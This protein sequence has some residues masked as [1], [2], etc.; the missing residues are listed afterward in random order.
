M[1]DDKKD[2]QENELA[3]IPSSIGPYDIKEKINEGGYSK[4]YLGISKYTNDKVAIKIIDK[5]LF[6]KNPED[7]LL[8]RNEIDILKLLKHR[9]ILTLYEIYESNQYFF[10]ITEHLSS[11]L[12]NLILNK[13]RLN[14]S[15]A[16]KIFVQLVDALQY[17][18]K[19]QICHR[20]IRVEHV[21]FDNNN[22]PKIID[23][24]YSCFYKKGKTL[25]EPIGSLSYAC[26][27][28]IQQK[29]YD[30]EL[31]DVWSLGVCLYVLLCGY[32]PFSEEDDEKNNKLIVSGKVDYPKEIGNVCK[33]LLKKM[34]EVNP[35]KRYNLLKISR[36]PWIKK[37][38]DVKIIGGCNIY[39]MVYPVDERI[40]KIVKEYGLDPKKVEEDLKS[41]KFNVNTGLFKVIVKKI[42]ELKLSSISDFTSNSFVDYTKDA[43]NKIQGGESKY[44]NYLTKL[45]ERN[46]K[47]QKNIFDY[48]KKEDNVINKL[49]EL[50]KDNENHNEKTKKEKA[51]TNKD[52]T[53]ILKSTK[54]LIS[55][56]NNNNSKK[57]EKEKKDQNPVIQ[58]FIE[59]YKQENSEFN[60][61]KS[62]SI[63]SYTSHG[64]NKQRKNSPKLFK[65]KINLDSLYE[66]P[67]TKKGAKLGGKNKFFPMAA[68]GR[69]SQMITLFRKPP[70]RLRRTSVSASQMQLLMRKPKKEEEEKKM[71]E[72]V[73]EQKDEE[74]NSEDSNESKS[75]KSVK[76]EKVEKE[77]KEKDKY[78]FDFGDD[79]DEEGGEKSDEELEQL[80]KQIENEDKSNN[81]IEEEKEEKKDDSWSSHNKDEEED[82]NL[83]KGTKCFIFDKEREKKIENLIIFNDDINLYITEMDNLRKYRYK[84]FS[85]SSSKIK[86]LNMKQ[87]NENDFDVIESIRTKKLAENK[88]KNENENKNNENSDVNKDEIKIKRNE[89]NKEKDLSEKDKEN[90]NENKT[91]KDTDF[92]IKEN[93]KNETELKND[94]R[95]IKSKAP[96]K[97]L[98]VDDKTL[99]DKK[100]KNIIV[101][102]NTSEDIRKEN[103]NEK[104]KIPNIIN[105]K[106][107]KE[108][109][110]YSNEEEEEEEED[111]DEKQN[112]NLTTINDL[113]SFKPN[114]TVNM[115]KGRNL[116]LDSEKEKEKENE[117]DKK[118]GLKNNNKNSLR[119]E[120]YKKN[121]NERKSNDILENEDKSE[122]NES[123]SNNKMERKRSVLDS[124]RKMKEKEKELKNKKESNEENNIYFQYYN[125]RNK[126]IDLDKKIERHLNSLANRP[127]QKTKNKK[128]QTITQY[129]ENRGKNGN[130]NIDG[131]YNK[132]INQS[133]I[134]YLIK[135]NLENSNDEEDDDKEESSMTETQNNSSK[136]KTKII[137][138][139]LMNKE[140]KKINNKKPIT[141][142]NTDKKNKIENEGNTNTQKEMDLY[143]S[144]EN[145]INI[146][147]F[148]SIKDESK[149]KD[150]ET[151]FKNNPLLNKIMNFNEEN[152]GDNNEEEEEEENK[153]EENKKK[154]N[155][156]HKNASVGK[157]AAMPKIRLNT[158]KN[159][160]ESKKYKQKKKQ[161]PNKNN[162]ITKK[163]NYKESPKKNKKPY[164][165]KSSHKSID[166]A[167]KK[168]NNNKL[169]NN[170]NDKLL[171]RQQRLEI[172]KNKLKEELKK[173]DNIIIFLNKY[174][175]NENNQNFE[176]E[177]EH[178]IDLQNNEN[179]NKN[180]STISS[181]E[182]D[183]KPKIKVKHKTNNTL[184]K[185]SSLDNKNILELNNN[186]ENEEKSTRNINNSHKEK[187]I[188]PDL[189]YNEIKNSKKF[190]KSQ[191]SQL[192]TYRSLN[193]KAKEEP[194]KFISNYYMNKENTNKD[195]L[196]NEYI[197]RS[198]NE[199]YEDSSNLKNYTVFDIIKEI[200]IT[201]SYNLKNNILENKLSKFKGKTLNENIQA[202]NSTNKDKS[203]KKNMMNKS[204]SPSRY[205]SKE[206]FEFNRLQNNSNSYVFYFNNNLNS[207]LSYSQ[208]KINKKD[209]SINKKSPNKRYMN[210]N[211]S[212]PKKCNSTLGLE[213][214][215]RFNSGDIHLSNNK[216]H[217][218]I[219]T[220]KSNY[221]NGSPRGLSKKG[222]K[223]NAKNSS[224]GQL[225]VKKTYYFMK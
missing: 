100:I 220:S 150:N 201:K 181:L 176:D 46:S 75:K 52:D 177:D 7:L 225:P 147:G 213:K 48:K 161:T 186:V 179:L 194:L 160:I 187:P 115:K 54:T 206:N 61:N 203:N 105:N 119:K 196:K 12:L 223:K 136:Q 34:L 130:E 76:E 218:N 217:K 95:E 63:Y 83:P 44:S 135:K 128:F 77:E 215:N 59:E 65:R 199:L 198:N 171:D 112:R 108:N 23:F 74:S 11:E 159:I 94:K 126:N 40:L 151:K 69:K 173:T 16:L 141:S 97:E 30:P 192:S 66:E 50:K 98:E 121:Q 116:N 19:M 10:L 210:D 2:G 134:P 209:F 15:D 51:T 107:L 114:Q 3:N 125:S 138:K 221:F 9:N 68:A 146:N 165:I 109:K 143:I 26:P 140:E 127:K 175:N 43:K 156:I 167:K 149:N 21:L 28:I 8:I 162:I 169:Y 70:A 99:K 152:E 96:E 180:I 78:S 22:V 168:N 17:I 86:K 110:R 132:I 122:S 184:K 31:A 101:P 211:R 208:S 154:N 182:K 82:K 53:S 5:T 41:N 195:E 148:T 1:L 174:N 183:N 166:V 71:D 39:E 129:K 207:D 145:E 113:I 158:N 72:I 123:L 178:I 80:K 27:E 117:N 202:S 103:K 84:F 73:E 120:S 188:I 144:R 185:E 33:D 14:E 45:E 118:N 29:S 111:E 60:T 200:N 137:P 193:T 35:K 56:N 90:D 190:N 36:H 104:R 131:D 102:K 106:N 87:K 6:I 18:H 47:I 42:W 214:I 139:K 170:K 216:I 163:N 58:Q 89:V 197:D 204:N 91:E 79:D 62:N 124:A 157:I 88:A 32:L 224:V 55:G 37:S 25:L 24:G 13:K 189:K 164:G 49:E 155:K 212:K 38:E 205:K 81:N 85:T 20:D 93:N 67:Q 153:Q 4:I 219:T 64:S 222:F 142:R 57:N 92:G 191:S 172:Q 133:K